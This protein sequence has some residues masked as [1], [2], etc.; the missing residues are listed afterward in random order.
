MKNSIKHILEND[1]ELYKY[2]EDLENEIDSTAN[3]DSTVDTILSNI[4]RNYDNFSDRRAL[5]ASNITAVTEL[6]KLK[7][8]LP[9]KRVQLKKT[10]LDMLSKKTELE[11]KRDTVK[12]T[13]KLAESTTSLARLLFNSLDNNNIQPIVV[14][15]ELVNECA[16]IIDSPP[17]VSNTLEDNA[18]S[19][20]KSEADNVN[21]TNTPDAEQPKLGED[22]DSEFNKIKIISAV[23]SAT[24]AQQIL[25][26]QKELESFNS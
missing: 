17:L 13:D 4:L 26:M 23:K 3:V 2:I 11:I 21:E 5:R 19:N 25:A 22:Y 6:L 12:S 7:S 10:I 18:E 15:A 14:D 8:D 24:S 1:E 16:D 20:S 9:T